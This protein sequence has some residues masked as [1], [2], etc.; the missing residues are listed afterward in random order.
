VDLSLQQGTSVGVKRLLLLLL[1][2]VVAAGVPAAA[3]AK[4]PCRNLVYNDWEHD[5]QIAS[6]YPIACY[7]DALRHIPST[8]KVYT[9]L[10][11]DIRAAMQAAL[12]RGQGKKVAA[13]VG[14]PF[15]ASNF[16]KP[17]LVDQS[18]SVSDHPLAT[19]SRSVHAAA[20]ATVAASGGG[21]PL[22]L[23][24]L[25][26]LALLLLASGAIGMVVRRRRGP[27]P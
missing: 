12:A 6:S 24:V 20:P 2:A 21:V 18:K 22:P 17:V 8:D 11:D 23:L 7:R 9:S 5:G 27:L 26:G 19:S 25:G 4:T 13:Q 10:E 15:A 14:H 16:V 1:L 3:E